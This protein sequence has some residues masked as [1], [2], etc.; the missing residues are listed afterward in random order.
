MSLMLA[1]FIVT[2]SIIDTTVQQESLIRIMILGLQ[3]AKSHLGQLYGFCTYQLN[4]I[5]DQESKDCF[6]FTISLIIWSGLKHFFQ[7]SAHHLGEPSIAIL[8]ISTRTLNNSLK[9]HMCSHQFLASEVALFHFYLEMN[10][11]YMKNSNHLSQ[12]LE[13][14]IMLFPISFFFLLISLYRYFSTRCI[15]ILALINA[16]AYVQLFTFET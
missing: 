15:D 2:H 4:M 1:W 16:H 10:S 14:M 8:G 3:A 5:V 7:Q 6:T 9:T 12:F 11:L 13:G